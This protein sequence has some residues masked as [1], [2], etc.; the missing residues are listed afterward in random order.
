MHIGELAEAE[1]D[2]LLGTCFLVMHKLVRSVTT[3]KPV[4]LRCTVFTFGSLSLV[5]RCILRNTT[6]W[7]LFVHPMSHWDSNALHFIIMLSILPWAA[8]T[9]QEWFVTQAQLVRALHL[10]AIAIV[11]KEGIWTG[12]IQA[13]AKVLGRAF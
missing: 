11:S 6:L 3:C 1:R 4:A 9:P 8:L 7:L 5:L 2:L 12:L 10:L 13:G